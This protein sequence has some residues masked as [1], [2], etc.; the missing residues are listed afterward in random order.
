MYISIAETHNRL[1]KL[2]QKLN[3]GPIT[4]TKRG[5]PVGVLMAP[6]EYERL[7]RVQAY[8]HLVHLSKTLQGSGETAVAL[9][10]ASRNELEERT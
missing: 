6:D 2:L 9:L 5:Q 4:I 3:D 10:D 1:S 8:L 7:Q